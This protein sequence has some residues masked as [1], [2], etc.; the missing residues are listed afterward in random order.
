MSPFDIFEACIR[1][2]YNYKKSI[3]RQTAFGKEEFR[4]LVVV[5]SAL[6]ESKI[7]VYRTRRGLC[8]ARYFC[9]FACFFGLAIYTKCT[10]F[11]YP[12]DFLTENSYYLTVSVLYVTSC[13]A[14]Y[15]GVHILFVKEELQKS[16]KRRKSY[17]WQ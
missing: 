4:K 7:K 8:L 13:N 3:R 5:M 12:L 10:N 15:G 1:P 6:P 14:N 9:D 11:S 17:G 2:N 16:T